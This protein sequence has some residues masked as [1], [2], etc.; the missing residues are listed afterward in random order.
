MKLVEK[1]GRKDEDPGSH[2]SS[3]QI[4]QVMSETAVGKDRENEV[5]GDMPELSNDAVPDLEFVGRQCRKEKGQQRDDQS[6]GPARRKSV[7]REEED[8]DQ[9]DEKRDPVFN[10]EPLHYWDRGLVPYSL[11][12]TTTLS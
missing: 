1:R 8:R 2:F 9:P 4:R 10:N 11:T 12:E 6:R 3:R 5:F 7:C